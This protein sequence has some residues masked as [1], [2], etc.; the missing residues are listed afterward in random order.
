M[1]TADDLIEV[2]TGL[3]VDIRRV[4]NDEINARCPVHHLTKGRES[5]RF[6]WYLN[7]DSGLWHCFTCGARGNLSMLVS[8]LTNDPSALWEVQSHLIH[9]GLDR[10]NSSDT[11][12][13]ERPQVDWSQYAQFEPLPDRV[14]N[15]RRLDPEVCQRYGI[16]WD[17]HKNAVCLPIVSS[18]G[19]LWGWQKKKTGWVRNHPVGVHKGLTLFGIERAHGSLGLLL[20]SP[21]DV[22]RFHTVYGASD[23]S[24][25]ASFGANISKTQMDLLSEKFDGLIIALDND[26]AGRLETKRLIKSLPSFRA[27]VKFWK[28]PDDCKDVGDMRDSQI[29]QALSELSSIYV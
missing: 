28:Y 22:V 20:E 6:S 12:I 19:E 7:V 10:I 4:Y 29:V 21:L 3:G 24:A 8:Q 16:R 13:E 11:V 14:V 25:I 9:S 5:G 23:I 18:R 17:D 27:G 1:S 26:P 2:L 15:S